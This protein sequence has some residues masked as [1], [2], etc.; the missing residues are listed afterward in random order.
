MIG[1]QLTGPVRAFVCSWSVSDT[2]IREACPCS[3]SGSKNDKNEIDEISSVNA[4]PAATVAVFAEGVAPGIERQDRE[5]LRDEGERRAEHPAADVGGEAFARAAQVHRI[6]VRQV[7]APEAELGDR[8]EA[9]EENADSQQRDAHVVK[10]GQPAH[11][12]TG[13]HDFVAARK[14]QKH[15]RQHDQPGNEEH[16]QQLAAA[17]EVDHEHRQRESAEQPARFLRLRVVGDDLL[18]RPAASRVASASGFPAVAAATFSRTVS[19]PGTICGICWI[20]PNATP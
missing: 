13:K 5:L 14:A 11:V 9:G 4:T 19:M 16:P 10:A 15:Q 20:A 7:V 2:F 18:R 1:R 8:E 3:G 17:G 6:H 12:E